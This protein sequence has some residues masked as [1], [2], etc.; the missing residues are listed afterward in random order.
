VSDP[1]PDFRNTPWS[2]LRQPAYGRYMAGEIIS[3]LGTW[4]QQLAQ[5]WVLA[6]LTTSAFTLGLV[7]FASGLPM[8][9]LTMYG[10]VIADRYDKRHILLIALALQAALAV[11]IGWLVGHG[12]IEV[13]HLVAAGMSLGIVIA[14]EMPAAS[15]LVPELVEKEQ[16]SAAIAVDRSIFHAT[17]LA[18]P[19]L[20]GW[21]IASLGQASAF[22]ANALSFSALAV[23]LL[24]IQP[25]RIEKPLADDGSRSGMREGL[26]YV[27]G[28]QQTLAMISMLAMA[29][30]CVSP[31]FMILMPMYSK[32]VL[33]IG[34]LQHGWLMA[35][36][37]LGAFAGSIWLLSIPSARRRAYLFASIAAITVAMSALAA[38]R[39]LPMAMTAMIAL[40]L[41]T[42]TVFGL[43]NTI[44]Q[45]RAPDYIRGRVSAIAGMSFFG[46]LPFSGLL[47]SKFA[48]LV[49]LRAAMGTAALC[50]G[51]G[52][53]LLLRSQ[54]PRG[55]S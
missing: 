10:G 49:G 2:V 38:A 19:A 15:A 3:M 18:G 52:A 37:G 45:E 53:A 29:T 46:V 55:E 24:T 54:R 13:W 16:L 1:S 44:V 40:T 17:R 6:G 39:S 51:L 7:N 4:T 23:A 32:H 27:R 50:F 48:D 34:S 47:I 22:Y 11:A 9:A 41:G 31:F 14:F 42:S 28:D 20:A 5:G 33:R 43:A 30:F 36:S 8:L 21:M 26:A 25:R 12:R 35:S